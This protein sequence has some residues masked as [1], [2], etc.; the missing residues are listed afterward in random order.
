MY[1]RTI[2]TAVVLLVGV[3]GGFPRGATPTF[4]R[5]TPRPNILIIVTD[6]QRADGTLEVMPQ[7]SYWFER[8]GTTF[9]NAFATTPWCCPSRASI[10]TG[11]YVHNH[12]VRDNVHA[13]LLDQRSTFQRY[14]QE[15][16]YKTG[17]SGK[18]MN[19]WDVALDPP[20][21]D[22]WAISDGGYENFEVNEDGIQKVISTY[23]TH[24]ASDK[25]TEFLADFDRHDRRPWLMYVAPYA[26]H[27][28]FKSEPVYESA[29]VPA[30]DGNP[31]VYEQDLSDKPAFPRRSVTLE[32]AL[33]MRR[34]QLRTLMSVDDMVGRLFRTLG[35]L[36]ERR[37]TLAI[38]VS[39]NGHLW[40]EHG[41]TGKLT[42][43]TQ[44]VGIPLLMRWPRGGVDPGA[45]DPRL[46]ANIDIAPTVLEAAEVEPE[47]RYP[48]DGRSL[49]APGAR[50]R[51]LL[52]FYGK[53]QARIPA[54]GSLRTPGYQ[55][56]EY[57][58]EGGFFAE[59]YNLRAD[60]WQLRNLLGDETAFNDPEVRDISRQLAADRNCVGSSC[61]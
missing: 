5:D 40:G 51:L 33:E 7:T 20:Y 36:G 17:I 58:F 57:D 13:E 52:E 23:S 11:Q 15:A 60:P 49:R 34:L 45:T 30:W 14:L 24:Y 4:A 42:P 43:Y 50:D 1:R 37:R 35:A 39:D 59:Y 54:W 29:P 21:W 9:S 55:Y 48:I 31:A 61:P 10:M 32:R 19:S 6:D 16:N 18:F 2:L 12:G 53:P 27:S 41:L 28:P 25:A 56:T 47:R 22:R 26:P 3:T 44:S 38:F 8:K 46:T